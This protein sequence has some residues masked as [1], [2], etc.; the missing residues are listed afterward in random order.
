[1]GWLIEFKKKKKKAEDLCL[2]KGHEPRQ[3]KRIWVAESNGLPV[4]SITKV[5]HFPSW[6][7]QLRFLFQGE[8]T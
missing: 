8:S 2:G 6:V 7:T 3:R 1:M 4:P 5:I